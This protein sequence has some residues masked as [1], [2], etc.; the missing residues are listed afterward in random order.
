MID[1][2]S[3]PLARVA[4]ALRTGDV[5]A[6]ELVRHAVDRHA[7]LDDRL[8]AYKLWDGAA[9]VRAARAAD[10]ARARGERI[11]PFHGI[12]VSVKDLYGQDGLPTYAGTARRLPDEWSRDAWL[13]ARLRDAG[14][15]FVGKTHTVE[16][17][18]AGVGMNPHWGTPWNPWDDRV[19]RIPG[20]S[21]SGAGVS[22]WEGSALVALGSDTGG[23][24]RI[25]AGMTGTVGHK[26]TYGRWPTA[27]VVPLSGT[28][29]SVGALTRSVDDAA[30]F[31]GSVDPAFGDPAAFRRAL[32]ERYDTAPRLSVPRCS[33]WNDCQGDVAD[34]LDD[35]LD[36]LAE[37]GFGRG[38]R[39]GALVDAA[40][41]HYLNAGIGGMELRDALERDLPGWLEILHPI[42][43]TRIENAP[44]LTDPS[45]AR[46][47]EE[48]QRLARRA[49]GLFT[50]GDLLA[51]PTALAT[52]R[53]LE[54]LEDDM[55]LYLRT[56]V[57]ALRPTCWVNML[58]LCAI[59][60]PAGLDESG[61]PVGLQ[62]VA[63]AGEDER[64]LAAALRAERVL[65]T[66]RERL[67]VP[68]RIA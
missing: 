64:L 14:A 32:E 52:P 46:A 27:G 23:S 7:A 18:F 25:P 31:F 62:L 4:E 20:G 35:A 61:M 49:G 51:L 26:L 48:H 67:G 10:E 1:V 5:S 39:D 66:A 3:A 21:S 68:P 65:G 59:T 38:T 42:V 37:A 54:G 22:L 6:E 63:P 47:I 29:D 12:P 43:G 19:R 11:G 44:P 36:E 24:I 34:V 50:D 28:F 58:G 16:L 13:V 2:A 45:Y 57:S 8:G 60:I 30:Y 41:D 55:R 40:A 56:N 15:I 17:A 33:L 53:P 9:A